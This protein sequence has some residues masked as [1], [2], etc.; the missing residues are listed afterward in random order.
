[1]RL[2]VLLAVMMLASSCLF[3]NAAPTRTVLIDYN[4]GAFPT[5]FTDHFPSHVQARQG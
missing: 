2:V 3:G 1:M 5:N 4:S